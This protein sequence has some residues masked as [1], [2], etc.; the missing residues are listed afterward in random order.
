MNYNLSGKGEKLLFFVGIPITAILLINLLYY[1]NFHG[2]GV[3]KSTT[4]WGEYG[5]YISGVTSILNLIVF[6]FLTVYVA[7]LGDSN[8][9]K[10]L[11]TQKKIIEAQFRQSELDKLVEQFNKPHENLLL[12]ECKPTFLSFSLLYSQIVYI[13]KQKKNIFP[14]LESK[15]LSIIVQTYITD[16]D[17]LLSIICKVDYYKQ[18]SEEAQEKYIKLSTQIMRNRDEII[19]QLQDSILADLE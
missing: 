4:V 1:L 3:S 5:S 12:S 18:L 9:K 15:E 7:Q 8:N 11:K 2:S 6:I 16:I 13:V 17:T 14:I 10:Q 19:R